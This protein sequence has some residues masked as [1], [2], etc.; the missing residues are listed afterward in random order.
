M[1]IEGTKIEDV[2]HG[3]VL[4]YQ[5][6]FYSFSIAIFSVE[7]VTLVNVTPQGATDVIHHV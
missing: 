6:F 4:T 3:M 7:G 1:R 5:Q 2:V